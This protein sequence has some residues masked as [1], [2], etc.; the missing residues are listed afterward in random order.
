[1]IY[2]LMT[3][4]VAAVIIFAALLVLEQTMEKKRSTIA[5]S[6]PGT[7]MPL[8]SAPEIGC[9]SCG[10]KFTLDREQCPYCGEK[11][12]I[13]WFDE[14]GEK[15]RAAL[16]SEHGKDYLYFEDK[17]LPLDR[18]GEMPPALQACFAGW[19]RSAFRRRL[20]KWINLN[21]FILTGILM[22]L[23]SA[24]FLMPDAHHRIHEPEKNI[25]IESYSDLMRQVAK[26]EMPK[27]YVPQGVVRFMAYFCLAYSLLGLV[28]G[29]VWSRY[30]LV[31]RCEN[32]VYFHFLIF[33][34]F[35][36][37]AWFYLRSRF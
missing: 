6:G 5:A 24:V 32:P 17:K 25:K 31:C 3:A 34:Q 28:T 7:G 18:L 37:G 12:K 14:N 19:Y 33:T 16:F 23:V 26:L 8:V 2:F 30:R 13:Y 29:R 15:K 11:V 10:Q 36:F 1:M 35:L 22:F 9:P 4:A 21:P 27:T 20:E